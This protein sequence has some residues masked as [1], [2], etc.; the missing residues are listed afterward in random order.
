M[1]GDEKLLN[2]WLVAVWPG[3]GGVALSAG[4]YLMSKL[5]MH[6][7]TEFP[8]NE[9]FDLN[10]IKIKDGL[11]VTKHLPRSR[12]FVWNDPR[13]QRDLIV[14]I[15]DAQPPA[16]GGAFCNKLLQQARALGVERVFTFAAMATAMRPKED[17]QIFA[18]ASDKET[19]ALIKQYHVKTLDN[20]T[21]S[22]LN[23][24]LLA[25]AADIGLP[26]ACLLGEIP[27]VFSQVPF[28]K[29]SLAVLGS[30]IQ[31][32]GIELDLDELS[33]HAN[34]AEQ[35]LESFLTRMEQAI[36]PEK[37]ATSDDE[38]AEQRQT[39]ADATERQHLEQ[40]FEKAKSDRSRAYEL[41]QELDR[42]ELFDEYED[43]FLDLF[44]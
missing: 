9:F 29:A 21:I 34:T 24:V 28:P 25:M 22:G 2:P 23:G 33:K 26:G 41:K 7:L 27:S 17:S 16:R 5:G 6:L 32:A 35:T 36:E 40:L 18:A 42:L 1:T 10:Q 31:L 13:K 39:L 11:I 43:R 4:Y 12:L 3:M 44:K 37:P 14:F 8:A 19:L 30:F 15:G 20:G 38:S